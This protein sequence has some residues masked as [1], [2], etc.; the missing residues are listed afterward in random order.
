MKKFFKV[1]LWII[2]GIVV[3]AAAVYLYFYIGWR[4]TYNSNLELLGEE[5]PVLT[6]A[7]FTFRDLNENGRLDVYEDGRADIEARID[8]L[9]SQ[10]NKEEKAG[11]LFITMQ[12]MSDDGTP[13]EIPELTNPFSLLL[14]TNS[15][16][17][18]AKKMTHFN[19]LMIPNAK[20]MV[21]WNNSIQKMAERT[22]LGIPITVASDPRHGREMNM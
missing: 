15:T 1:L 13:N 9:I 6:E 5:A 2:C 10:M 8:D 17:M 20:A 16:M 21:N 12:V 11:S 22:R 3:L 7:G 4:S 19:V 14:E 18:L